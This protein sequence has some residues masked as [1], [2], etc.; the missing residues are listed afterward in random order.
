MLAIAKNH[1][2]PILTGIV[3]VLLLPVFAFLQEMIVNIGQYTGTAI[4]M[5]V[6]GIC[7]K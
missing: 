6:E 2:K 5:H 1:R 4:R 3:I 7:T